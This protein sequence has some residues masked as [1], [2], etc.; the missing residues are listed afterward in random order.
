M[1]IIDVKLQWM[2]IHTLIIMIKDKAN[3]AN[4][5]DYKITKN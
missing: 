3:K 1:K 5:F 4:Y 2:K